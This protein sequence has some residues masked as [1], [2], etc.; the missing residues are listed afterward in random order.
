MTSAR[1]A[2][3]RIVE[4]INTLN[5]EKPLENEAYDELAPLLTR[6]DKQHSQ[7]NKHVKELQTARSELAAIMDN[8]REG[9]ILLDSK[10]HILSMNQ[11]AADIFCVSPTA[12]PSTR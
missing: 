12:P 5:L 1:R 10:D 8:M 2:A 11:S 4:P 6:M 7:I 9:M 3:K